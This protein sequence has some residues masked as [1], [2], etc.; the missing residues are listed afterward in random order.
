MKLLSKWNLLI[1]RELRA[2]TATSVFSPCADSISTF[3]STRWRVKGAAQ[4]I[5]H[6]YLLRIFCS[7]FE[8]RHFLTSSDS[9]F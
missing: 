9:C 8:E 4:L 3:K 2:A 7:T 6:V 1:P 5:T